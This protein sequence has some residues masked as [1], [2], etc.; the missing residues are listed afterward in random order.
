MAI[1][2]ILC[3]MVLLLAILI[4]VL[5]SRVETVISAVAKLANGHLEQQKFITGML[6]DFNKENELLEHRITDVEQTIAELP[7][8]K[9]RENAEKESDFLDGLNGIINFDVG[10]HGLNLEG[11]K[12]E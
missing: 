7:I 11:V 2:A 3:A 5:W 1:Q 9:L 6:D 12:H 10:S 8:E 4:Y